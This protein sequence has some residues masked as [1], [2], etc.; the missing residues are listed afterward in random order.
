MYPSLDC[1]IVLYFILAKATYKRV[2]VDSV[3]RFEH[4]LHE[5]I[6][7]SRDLLNHP[8]SK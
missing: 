7:Y 8:S 6:K 1:I 4:K 5:I 3:S 2:L